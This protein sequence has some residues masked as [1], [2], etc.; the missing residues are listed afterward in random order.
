M[1]YITASLDYK[2]DDSENVL[3]E[4]AVQNEPIFFGLWHFAVQ[5]NGLPLQPVGDWTEICRHR[6]RNCD[7]L[8]IDLPLENGYRL[9]R[10]VLVSHRDKVMLLAD[11]VL[12]DGD[13]NSIRENN[14]AKN[15]QQVRL[16]QLAYQS[17]LYYSPKLRSKISADTTEILFRPAARQKVAPFRVLPLALPEWSE[18]SGNGSLSDE[19]ARL[20]LRQTAA[21]KNERLS[22]FAPL[23]IDLDA[24]RLG[25]QYT[26][27][28][29]TV[30]EN[31]K[32]VPDNKAVGFRV[33]LA[34]S[35]FLIY[36]SLTQ[37]LSNRT[38]LGH[39]LIDDFCFA[40]F[41]PE[42]GVDPLIE[43]QSATESV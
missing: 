18:Q 25:K 3:F 12:F 15:Q 38:V 30:G 43:I 6:E 11:T 23:F 19:N 27:R 36:R 13:D 20:V 9:Q 40:R 4:V 10:S 17:E 16:T 32:R 14:S 21:G 5:L 26:W 42:T 1:P 24:E 33:Q 2:N 41:S 8:E 37:G 7:Y 22:L 28:R 29:L 34:Q 35:Q 39:N 31:L